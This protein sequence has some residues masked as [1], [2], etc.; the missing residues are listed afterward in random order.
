MFLGRKN[1]NNDRY[2]N[3]Y[4]NEHRGV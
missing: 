1:A 4:L 3:L 2:Q